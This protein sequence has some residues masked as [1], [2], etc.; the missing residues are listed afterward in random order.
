MSLILLM[1]AELLG[2]SGKSVAPASAGRAT[3]VCKACLV[4][5]WLCQASQ[6]ETHREGGQVLWL[7]VRPRLVER[8]LQ[9]KQPLSSALFHEAL[10]AAGVDV[11][12]AF[13]SD[14]KHPLALGK[15][16]LFYAGGKSLSCASGTLC[17]QLSM[18]LQRLA[19]KVA[20]ANC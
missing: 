18:S 3:L 13:W 11:N 15:Y 10:L 1:R 17:Q 7:P 6:V 4:M 2:M 14:Y 8:L 5:S 19:C 12:T 16:V 9:A 20:A